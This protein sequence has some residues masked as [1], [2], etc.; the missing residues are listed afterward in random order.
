MSAHEL[1]AGIGT[2]SRVVE[3]GPGCW[4]LG[5]IVQANHGLRDDLTVAGVRVGREL[6]WRLEGEG[7]G[8]N[9]RH[10]DH[11]CAPALPAA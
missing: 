3:S 8:L 11:R 7:I 6:E 5:V 9:Y 4:T 1:K 10:G 2:A